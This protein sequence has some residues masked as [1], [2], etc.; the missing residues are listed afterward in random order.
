MQ[1]GGFGVLGDLVVGIAGA[2]VGSWLLPQLHIQIGY[3]IVAA[4]ANA[5]VGALVILVVIALLR[6]GN[7]W[8]GA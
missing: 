3:G 4:I 6:G 5:T 1:G 2:F 8:R 7:R